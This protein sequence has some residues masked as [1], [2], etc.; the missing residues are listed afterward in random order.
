MTTRAEASPSILAMD[1]AGAACSAALWRDGRVVAGRFEPMRRGHAERL[2]PMIE[3]VMAEAG[4]R[5]ADVDRLAVTLGPGGF[6][7]VRIGL[8]TAQGLAL[9]SGRPLV[10]V[11]NFLVL[12][13][14]ARTEAPAEGSLAVAIDAKRQDFYLQIFAADLRPRGEPRSIWPEE[15]AEA[16]PPGPLLLVGDG[17]P[18]AGPAL[19]AAGRQFR[20]AAAPA[21]ADAARLAELVAADVSG[22]LAAAPV[23][24]LYLRPPDVTPAGGR[25]ALS[26]RGRP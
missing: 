5:Y 17:A 3:A 13:A 22:A 25:T 19:A 20:L 6:T 7:G 21:V 9:A 18:Q 12:A 23:E 24:P 8:A 16:V 10:G 26:G 15:L 1:A 2:V 14:A 4:A 11:S